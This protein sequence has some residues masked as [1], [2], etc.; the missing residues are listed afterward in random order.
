[1]E[2]TVRLLRIVFTIG[3]I[4]CL[5][6]MM[7]SRQENR[8]ELVFK[9]FLKSTSFSLYFGLIYAS[10]FTKTKLNYVA[11][12]NFITSI[13]FP[14]VIFLRIEVLQGENPRASRSKSIDS[15]SWLPSKVI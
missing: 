10:S 8:H 14:A 7:E 2:F 9:C 4:Q 3:L 1:M 15:N 5:A 12:L 13:I 11:G 6:N